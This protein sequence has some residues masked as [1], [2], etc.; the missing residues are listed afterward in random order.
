MKKFFSSFLILSFAAVSPVTGLAQDPMPSESLS[1]DE[2]AVVIESYKKRPHS[3]LSKLMYLKDLLR[4]SKYTILYNG[5][6]YTPNAIAAIIT[7][8]VQINYKREPAEDWIAKHA[9][10]SPTKGQIIYLKHP[11]GRTQVLKDALIQEL[12]AL[13]TAA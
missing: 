13:P 4:K 10:R 8:Y 3:E 9:Y 2:R 5:R 11:D 6:T 1:P 12:R 7:A